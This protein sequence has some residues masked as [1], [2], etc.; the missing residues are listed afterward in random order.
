MLH[1]QCC[2]NPPSTCP[3]CGDSGDP[4]W[5]KGCQWESE[6]QSLKDS[7]NGLI[8]DFGPIDLDATTVEWPYPAVWQ[9]YDANG[10]PRVQVSDILDVPGS[11][12]LNSVMD[13]SSGSPGLVPLGTPMG[14]GQIGV[15][16]SVSEV[17][18]RLVCWNEPSPPGLP[19]ETNVACKRRIAVSVRATFNISYTSCDV[20]LGF[21]GY[22]GNGSYGFRADQHITD[23]S[24]LTHTRHQW[25]SYGFGQSFELVSLSAPASGWVGTDLSYLDSP[26]VRSCSDVT[27][28]VSVGGC[29]IPSH[30]YTI[31][32]NGLH[33]LTGTLTQWDGT[34]VVW[35]RKFNVNNSNEYMT[36]PADGDMTNYPLGVFDTGR[37]VAGRLSNP[38]GWI[39]GLWYRQGATQPFRVAKQSHGV[40]SGLCFTLEPENPFSSIQLTEQIQEQL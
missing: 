17:K 38:N 25:V 27:F 28:D 29:S 4:W 20:W 3:A 12:T 19:Y 1:P 24:R 37:W 16:V 6:V 11:W 7:L 39:V 35:G 5:G 22:L 30:V 15:T 9:Q 10:L 2:C 33:V 18:A 13:W 23:V 32:S 31:P 36:I 14:N 34:I 26:Q 40:P 21:F 8:M